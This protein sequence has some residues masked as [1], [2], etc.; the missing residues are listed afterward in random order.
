MA[1]GMTSITELLFVDELPKDENPR[2]VLFL[3][4]I[5]ASSSHFSN[6]YT[7]VAYFTPQ[8]K[9]R[10]PSEQSQQ[11]V[12]RSVEKAWSR[13]MAPYNLANRLA[14]PLK[15]VG[16]R[17]SRARTGTMMLPLNLPLALQTPG[18]GS[19]TGARPARK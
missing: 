5:Y 10:I 15:E 14:T 16:E 7:K 11:L 3:S 9:Y 19:S 8:H 6:I 18:A 2:Y 4:G 1:L 12:A 17:R 13:R